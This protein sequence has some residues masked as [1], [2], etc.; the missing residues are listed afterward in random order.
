MPAL[1]DVNVLP[2]LVPDRHA[3]HGLAAGW[4]DGVSVGE[5]VVCRAAAGH[6]NGPRDGA[7]P[8]PKAR[9]R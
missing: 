2:A 7:L 9:E 4:V 1:G 3:F 6:T 8:F 5:A